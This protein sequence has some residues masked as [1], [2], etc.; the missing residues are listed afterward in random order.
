MTDLGRILAAAVMLLGIGF[1]TVIT[2]SITGAFVARSRREQHLEDPAASRRGR[3]AG[4]HRPPRAHRGRVGVPGLGYARGDAGRPEA[5]R[6]RLD[7][8]TRVIG[9]RRFAYLPPE[10]LAARRDRNVRSIVRYAAATVPFY[11]EWF[12]EHGLDPREI[13]GAGDLARLPVIDKETL[14]AEQHRLVSESR[15]GRAAFPMQTS[16]ST[17]MPL[18]V[19]QGRRLLFE[20]AATGERERQVLRQALGADVP[21]RIASVGYPGNATQADPAAGARV[22]HSSRS[23]SHGRRSPSSTRSSISWPRSTASARRC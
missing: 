4:D 10:K 6:Q 3:P 1:V 11:R 22:G 15:E 13:T 12:R 8:R 20:N 18:T 2:A 23:A 9:Q 14:Q 19:Y 21:I 7:R 5:R 16:G 17:G